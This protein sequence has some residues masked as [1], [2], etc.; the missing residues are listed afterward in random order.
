[1]S[2]ATAARAENQPRLG[3]AMVLLF[4][5]ACGLSAANLYYAQPILPS[6]SKTFGTSSGTAGLIVTFAQIGYAAGLVLLVPLGDLLAR[7]RLV[8]AL[9]TVTTIALLVS[10]AAPDIGVLIGV[11]LLVGAGSVAAQVLV[12]M[13]ATLAGEARRGQVVGTVMSGLLLGILLARTVSGVVAGVSSWRVVYAVA[14]VLSMTV[15]VILGRLLPQ[16]TERPTISY[17][18]LLRTALHLLLTESILQRRAV[19]GAL[20]FA[21]FSVFWTTMAFVLAGAPYHY[22]DVTIGLFGLVGAGGA[23]CANFAGRWADREL[24]KLTTLTFAACIALSFLPLWIGRHSLAMLIIG[25]LVL[26]VGVQ[27]LQVT[28]QSMIYRLPPHLRSRITSAYMACY[29][30]GGA[31]GSAVGGTVYSS[32]G[33]GGVCVLGVGIGITAC[34]AAVVDSIRTHAIVAG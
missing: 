23:L 31:A 21:A 25:I 3:R 28:N 16:E 34:I 14:A 30:V 10:A 2:V 12:P 33:W 26:D 22:G 4:A 13:A 1:V 18:T 20:G 19:F 29:F 6:I 15:A 32:H 11:S 27:G 17:G 8:P 5:V 7:R 24:T 9:L